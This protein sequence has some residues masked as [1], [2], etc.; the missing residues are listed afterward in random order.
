[1]S[2]PVVLIPLFLTAVVNHHLL[3]PL[4]VTLSSSIASLEFLHFPI[5]PGTCTN[6]QQL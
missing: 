1:M 3:G 2:L 4:C 5:D 6:R